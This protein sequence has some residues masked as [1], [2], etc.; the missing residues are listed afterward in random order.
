M[1]I[2]IPMQVI[3]ARPG[4]ARVQGRGEEREISTALIGDCQPGD[5]LLIFL[6]GA[7]ER[8]DVA[9]AA[10]VNA[11]LDLLAASMAGAPTL[12]FNDP[13]FALPSAMSATQLAELAGI[14]PA[15]AARTPI[16]STDLQ[17]TTP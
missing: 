5:W 15:G 13:G 17:E 4:L 11:T 14:A 7:R 16:P 2:G 12:P 6:D 10:E 3:A 1:C 9:R 8:L